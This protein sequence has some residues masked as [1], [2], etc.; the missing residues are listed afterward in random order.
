MIY[1]IALCAS[2]T[3][4]AAKCFQQLN[5]VHDM[6]KAAVLT[7]YVIA[8]FETIIVGS[9]ATQFV[10]NGIVGLY[11]VI[12]IGTGGA[13]GVLTSMAIHKHLRKRNTK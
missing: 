4:V 10:N 3:A 2:Y 5:V 9:V 13:L 12:P 7:S 6:R 8:F 1:T 11:L